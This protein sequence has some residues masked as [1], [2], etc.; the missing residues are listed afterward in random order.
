MKRK[1]PHKRHVALPKKRIRARAE[2]NEPV[3]PSIIKSPSRRYERPDARPGS[4]S[5][6]NRPPEYGGE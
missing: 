4:Q 6:S 3:E 2:D 1:P 5:L